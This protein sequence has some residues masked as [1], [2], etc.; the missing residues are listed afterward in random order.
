MVYRRLPGGFL[1]VTWRLTGD[2][3]W[4]WV[5]AVLA[6]GW[7]HSEDSSG[8]GCF[9]QKCYQQQLMWLYVYL[10]RCVCVF[11]ICVGVYIVCILVCLCKLYAHS[12]AWDDLPDGRYEHE[13]TS[14]CF[15]QFDGL[16]PRMLSSMHLRRCARISHRPVGCRKIFLIPESMLIYVLRSIRSAVTSGAHSEG[17]CVKRFDVTV[18]WLAGLC[19]QSWWVSWAIGAG[20][21]NLA[22]SPGGPT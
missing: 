7:G 13:S 14:P 16:P 6:T 9:F 4:E 22:P 18:S 15:F 2:S 8:H 3:S 21:Q 5:W 17:P 1:A 20:R 12:R 11:V 10:C 19:R